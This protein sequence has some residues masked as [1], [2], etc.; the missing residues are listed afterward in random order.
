[1]TIAGARLI[2]GAREA[3]AVARGDQP[4]ASIFV[5]GHRYISEAEFRR[6]TRELRDKL[7]ERDETIRQLRE[8]LDAR[9]DLPDWLP[10]LT[11]TERRLLVLL[12]D[13]RLHSKDQLFEAMYPVEADAPEEKI[14]DVF[15]CKLRR[16]LDPL[17][18]FI[19]THWSRGYRL[20][21]EGL[22]I[23]LGTRAVPA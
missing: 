20:S 22:A 16:K 12:S 17:E 10:H 18:I 19:E 2:E 14:I 5:Q 7:D 1:M 9:P 21:A 4:A 13:G 3:L 8:R 11:T 15:V 6:Q 23:L